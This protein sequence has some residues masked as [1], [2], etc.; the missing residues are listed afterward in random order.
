MKLTAYQWNIKVTKMSRLT[1]RGQVGP[2]CEGL[3]WWNLEMQFV[4][5]S[6]M[7]IMNYVIDEFVRMDS[8]TK[9]KRNAKET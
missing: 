6:V 8:R 9:T 2:G 3:N 7:K 4:R 1:V 5:T